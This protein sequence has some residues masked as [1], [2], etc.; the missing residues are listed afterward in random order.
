MAKS[1]RKKV[2]MGFDRTAGVLLHPTSFPGPYGMGEL[3]SEAYRFADYLR[4]A[5]QGIWQVLPLVPTGPGHSPYQSVST[6]AGN[7][8]LISVE[9]L[10]NEGLLD[11]SD[12]ES[13]PAFPD[14][15][16]DFDAAAA[17]KLPLLRKAQQRFA[18]D[19][20][21]AQRGDYERFLSH[22]ALW[23]DDYAPFM[24]I[25]EALG[26]AC[27]VNWPEE[28]AARRP[29]ALAQWAVDHAGEVNFHRF[30]QYM[31]AR[32]WAWL[33]K[34]CNERGI[35]I[36][37]DIPIYTAHDSVDCWAHPDL[38]HLDEQGWPTLVAGVPPDYFSAT[39]QLWGNPIY[40]WDRL[41]ETGYQ[42][43]ID[44]MRFVFESFDMVRIDHFRGFEAYWE[45]P[46]SETTAINGRWVEG[47][48]TALF[49][50][51]RDALGK[52][53]IVAENL[54]I[55]TVEVES[56]RRALGLP[57]MAVLQFAFGLDPKNPGLLPHTYTRDT[58][59]YT[60][61]HDN[62]TTVGWWH[63]TSGNGMLSPEGAVEERRFAKLYTASGGNE[64]HWDFIRTIFASPA[65][66]AIVPL[67][68]V[69]G[70]GSE[71]RMNTPGTSGGNWRWRY[72][73]EML[74]DEPRERLRQ[75][76]RLYGRAE[77]RA[78]VEALYG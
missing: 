58:A 6:F 64:I 49:E 23:V 31:F 44:R 25:K 68:D 40:R 29:E 18:A 60:G 73:R 27:W 74:A 34:Y 19:A 69:L 2:Y 52:L 56:M 78:S 4:G 37:G 24:A 48:R 14:D 8:L 71:A 47:P 17:W 32:H 35:R 41:A 59:A 39:G 61:T 46:A 66:L 33:R 20:S 15:C 57:G 43:W 63:D 28:L 3:G 54:G 55:I 10:R 42:W 50:A 1:S 5:D 36:M 11:E 77:G 53:P 22:N 67:Q 76:T 38:F 70:L 16:A 65:D 13:R 72:R 9:Q 7:P 30:L 75:L 12:L 26:G 45:V 51:I 21:P 62:D